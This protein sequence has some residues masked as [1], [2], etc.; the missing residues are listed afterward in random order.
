MSLAKQHELIVVI[1]GVCVVC[2]TFSRFVAFFNP[3]TRLMWA[4]HATTVQFLKEFSISY[5]DVMRSIVAVHQGTVYRGSDAFITILK[6]MPWYLTILGYVIQIFPKFIREYV[7]GL[8]SS[9]RYSLFGQ[10]DSCQR[11][12][13]EL[14]AKFLHP[15]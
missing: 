4:Q 1:D 6:T 14:R 3:N 10:N 7:Y 11:P 2:S 13:S 15:V 12:S 5:D 9:N 8:V